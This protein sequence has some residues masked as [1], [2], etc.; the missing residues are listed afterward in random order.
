MILC[1]E[2]NKEFEDKNSL[3][4]ELKERKREVLL[5]KKAEPKKADGVPMFNNTRKAKE[6][7]ED[8]SPIEYGS[9][10]YPVINTTLLLDSHQDV[11]L[12]GLWNKS[13]KEQVGKVS[14]IT[15]HEFKVGSV[16]SFPDE[17][18][19]MVKVMKWRDLGYDIDGETEALI[20]ESTL[21]EDSNPTAFGMYKRK[22]PVQHSVHMEYI[23]LEL[24]V[25]S[26]D[27]DWK[28]ERKNWDK[29]LPL[30]VNPENAIKMGYFWAVKEARI[31]KEGSM[32]LEGSNH[33][34]PALYNLEAG[35]S[36]S[37][38]EPSD[39]TRL[40]YINKLINLTNQ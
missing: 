35:K 6:A 20:F 23:Q 26:D 40:Q 22:R 19:P 28:S 7:D 9:K 25:D 27:E 30:I 18:V 14:L 24:A 4:S 37:K 21:S 10:V 29:Y 15:N 5:S 32:V 3:L 33:I 38:N 36:T 2:L 39:D 8:S 17:T 13:V 12:N 31:Y 1:K 16:I 11:H 34:T